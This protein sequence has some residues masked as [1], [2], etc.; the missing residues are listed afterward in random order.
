M[1]MYDVRAVEAFIDRFDDFIA[2]L[3]EHGA[4]AKAM[5]GSAILE[6]GPPPEIA[7]RVRRAAERFDKARDALVVARNRL[8]PLRVSPEPKEGISER[9]WTPKRP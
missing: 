2:A 8:G 9:L 1:A 5:Q 6:G 7:D 4:A 3:A